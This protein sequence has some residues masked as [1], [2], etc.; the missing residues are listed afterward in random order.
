MK[1]CGIILVLILAISQ[2]A[3]GNIGVNTVAVDSTQAPQP[4]RAISYS[5]LPGGGQLY[6]RKPLK[7]ALFLGAFAYFAY[8]YLVADQNLQASPNDQ[9]LHRIRNDQIWLMS[10]TWTLN[11]LD[12]YVDAELWDFDDY[13]INDAETPDPKIEKPKEIPHEQ[14]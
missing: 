3:L 5:L 11:L 1:R 9:S 10:L 2:M 14:K 7:A 4:L 6:N 12:A 13:P 8:Q